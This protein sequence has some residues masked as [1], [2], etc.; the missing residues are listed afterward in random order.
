M[1]IANFG[2]IPYGHTILGEL[3]FIE[4]NAEGCNAFQASLKTEKQQSP[5]AIVRRGDC[6]FIQKVRNVEHG[7][8]KLAIVVDEVDNE[9][10]DMIIMVDDG[11]G[12]GIQIPSILVSKTDGEKLIKEYQKLT[13]ENTEVKLIVSFDINKPD[14]R[15]E[16]DIWF[17]SSNDRGL[18]FIRDFRSY[19]ETLG[20]K[21]LMTPRYF[22]WAC[23]NCD[24]AITDIDC[25][26][27]G[28]YCS[29]DES[30][31]R[32]SG[33]DIM[34]ENLR[35]KCIYLNTMK[36]TNNDKLWWTYVTKAHSR[37]YDD[38][39]EDCSKQIHKEL[40]IDFAKTEK[41]VTDSFTDADH[42]VGDN[43]LLAEEVVAWNNHGSH[44]IPSV[45]I[46]SVSYRGVLDPENVFSAICNGFKDVQEECQAYVDGKFIKVENDKVSFNWFI[47]VI[48]FL[49]ILNIALLL[50]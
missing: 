49:I 50:I 7:G 45:I 44:Y 32:V 4:D 40:G 11:T 9:N 13:K 25:F 42:G 3:R 18:D 34:H 36:E 2:L 22:T 24:S 27:D 16:Y 6:S 12:N 8:G 15:V 39:S 21:V 23:I 33:R 43:T 10:P 20:K 48:I 1:S 30:N 5:I 29:I 31:L 26:C 38:F 19:H 37:C 46:N 28:K 47:V 35:Q 41:C 14:D 17:S